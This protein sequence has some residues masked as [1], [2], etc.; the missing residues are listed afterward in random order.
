MEQGAGLQYL[1]PLPA[2][3]LKLPARCAH[4]PTSASRQVLEGVADRIVSTYLPLLHRL[5]DAVAL[6]DMLHGFALVASGAS[7]GGKGSRGG[8]AAAAGAAAAGRGYVRPVLTEGGPIALVEARHPVLECLE[9]GTYQ[10]N[11]TFLALNSS[12]HIITGPNMSGKSTYLRQVALCCVTAQVGAFVPAAFASLPPRDRLLSRLGTGD[13]LET[14]S[15]SFLLEMQEVAYILGSAT[16][17]SLVL[18]DELGRATSTADGVG[19][20]WAVSEALLAAGAP[21]L[22]AT[23]FAQLTELVAV[24]PAAKAW[25]FDVGDVA[26]R[27]ALDFTWRLRAGACEAGHYGLLLATAVG[28]PDEV[29]AAAEEVVAALDA[30]EGQRVQAYTTADAAELEAVYDVVQ[31][32]ACLA[33]SYAD[34][35]GD[36]RQLRAAQKQLRRLRAEAEDA[37]A[38]AREPGLSAL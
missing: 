9:Q 23:H 35:G 37:L 21:T 1:Y 38:A 22:F 11:D 27:R 5:V 32:L 2:C 18:I 20:A 26:G 28:F 19:I 17:Q 16:P 12:L 15:S 30:S 6:L 4:C 31:K 24:Y 3:Q 33:Q 13:S 36:E 34:S 25:H 29:L 8:A 14:C 10:P 7:G